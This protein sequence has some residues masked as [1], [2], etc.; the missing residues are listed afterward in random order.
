MTS[1]F[2]ELACVAP[3]WCGQMPPG[4]FTDGMFLSDRSRKWRAAFGN[5]FTPFSAPSPYCPWFVTGHTAKVVVLEIC[6]NFTCQECQ[7]WWRWREGSTGHLTV[8]TCREVRMKWLFISDNGW[9]SF[10]INSVGRQ[11]ATHNLKKR[12]DFWL[13]WG[14]FYKILAMHWKR[15]RINRNSLSGCCIN[16]KWQILLLPVIIRIPFF[17]N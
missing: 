15:K 8:S 5:D 7:V 1:V 14:K 13:F 11:K 2:T 9:K 17:F 12:K 16:L 4:C 6:E 10:R 3:P